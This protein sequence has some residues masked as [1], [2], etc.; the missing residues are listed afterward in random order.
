MHNEK[1]KHK[2]KNQFFCHCTFSFEVCCPITFFSNAQSQKNFSNKVWILK[3]WVLSLYIELLGKHR[4]EIY[5]LHFLLYFYFYLIFHFTHRHWSPSE[6]SLHFLFTLLF[7]YYFFILLI[8]TIFYFIFF[9][10]RQK[11]INCNSLSDK[12]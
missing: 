1:S 8:F 5:D 7:H 10:A 11:L 2:N 4:N 12:I 9:F 3:M 6:F